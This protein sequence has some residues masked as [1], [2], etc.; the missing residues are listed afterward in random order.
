MLGEAIC[1][2]R[3]PRSALQGAGHLGEHLGGDGR[4]QVG[5]DE[6]GGLPGLMLEKRGELVRWGAP[7]ELKRPV[8]D[9]AGQAVDQFTGPVFPQGP[10][11]DLAGVVEA[12]G[13]QRLI[14]ADRGGQFLQHGLGGGRCDVLEL[15]HLQGERFD[16]AVAEVTQDL[17]GMVGPERD[18]QHSRL[19]HAADARRGHGRETLGRAPDWV[20]RILHQPT[21]G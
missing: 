20:G 11:E 7:Q 10:F 4:R 1:A 6:R 15:G 13:G 17:R 12:A 5:D 18:Q 14:G 3:I 8:L 16:L 9:R 19:L 21:S 2:I